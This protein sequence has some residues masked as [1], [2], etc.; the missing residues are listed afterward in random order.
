MDKRI[1]AQQQDLKWLLM[2]VEYLRK[3]YNTSK[4]RFEPNEL[5]LWIVTQ[6]SLITNKAIA[7]EL[8]IEER[9]YLRWRSGQIPDDFLKLM[10]ANYALR[11]LRDRLIGI[12]GPDEML[13]SITQKNGQNVRPDRTK[14]PDI[15]S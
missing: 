9:T 15:L 5:S 7:W 8:D 11:G 14:C 1:A 2:D 6:G 10:G 4:A 13:K 12:L 3:K